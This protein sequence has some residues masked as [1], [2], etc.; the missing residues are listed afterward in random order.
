[1]VC[2]ALLQS[3]MLEASPVWVLEQTGNGA[4]EKSAQLPF[5]GT[6]ILKFNADCDC[7][8]A[9]DSISTGYQVWVVTC[10]LKTSAINHMD[11]LFQADKSWSKYPPDDI[12]MKEKKKH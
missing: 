7:N 9:L 8:R 6:Q 3:V 2:L 5:I 10:S 4:K 11:V 1:M 12:F